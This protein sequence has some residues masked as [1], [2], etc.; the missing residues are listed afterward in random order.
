MTVVSIGEAVTAASSLFRF[1]FRSDLSARA[2]G[3]SL[4]AAVSDGDDADEDD[5]E[6]DPLF[7]AVEDA[8]RR[9]GYLDA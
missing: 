9:A 4:L 1:G 6:P 7:Q 8:L 2:S 5:G 3:A